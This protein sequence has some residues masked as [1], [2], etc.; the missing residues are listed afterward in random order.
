MCF[1]PDLNMKFL[2]VFII[3]L[4][5]FNSAFSTKCYKCDG[6]EECASPEEEDCGEG[7]SC[8]T[9]RVFLGKEFSRIKKYCIWKCIKEEWSSSLH[10]L[11]L[12][13]TCCEG[14]LCNAS[15][16]LSK[17]NLMIFAVIFQAVLK[18]FY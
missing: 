7:Y 13:F 11:E 9:E 8:L 3:V 2:L 12:K 1:I 17:T 10:L 16:N 5:L 18:L 6:I 15:G 14:D 4:C